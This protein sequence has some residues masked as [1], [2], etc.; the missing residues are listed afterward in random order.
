MWI[1]RTSIPGKELFNADTE[2]CLPMKILIADSYDNGNT[3]SKLRKVQLPK[4][5]GPPSLTNPIMKLP[6][7]KLIMSCLL[8]T[9]PSPRD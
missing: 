8:Y 5:I 2:G 4:D 1:D 3:W 6:N 9:S 7:G